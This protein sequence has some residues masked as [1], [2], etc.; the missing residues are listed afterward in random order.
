MVAIHIP[1]GSTAEYRLRASRS[2]L[3][4]VRSCVSYDLITMVRDAGWRIV[5]VKTDLVS[6]YRDSRN[7]SLE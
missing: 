2:G 4:L 1:D 3:R 7:K 6:R 5:E